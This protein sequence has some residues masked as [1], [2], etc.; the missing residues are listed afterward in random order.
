MNLGLDDA[1]ALV[2]GAG[3]GIGRAV[4]LELARE[5]AH[6]VVLDVRADAAEDTAAR[7]RETGAEGHPVT[8]DLADPAAIDAA[9][10]DVIA[11]RGAPSA[12]C[13]NAGIGG[14]GTIETLLVDE[15]RQILAVNLDANLHLLRGLLGPMSEAGGGSI[16]AVSSPGAVDAGHPTSSTAYGVSKAGLERLMLDVARRHGRDGIR[17]NVVRPGPVDTDFVAHRLPG[18]G[19]T[20]ELRAPAR[21]ARPDEIAAPIAFLLSRCADLVT[22]QTVTVDGG[23]LHP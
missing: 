3:G 7:V 16:V 8:C 19:T 10:A 4:A 11:W 1:V 18:A 23:L 21:R 6:V 20:P 15:W 17:A 13:L 5:G 9:L 12:I 2:T 22:G 14:Y